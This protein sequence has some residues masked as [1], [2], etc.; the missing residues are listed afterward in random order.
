[1]PSLNLDPVTAALAP[2]G[3]AGND[4][5]AVRRQLDHLLGAAYDLL[6]DRAE[7]ART[8]EAASRA[9][10]HVGEAIA[11]LEDVRRRIGAE[12]QRQALEEALLQE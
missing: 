5:G 10:E 11:I 2:A 9:A 4:A 7:G 3:P 12:D 1:M 6:L 8:P